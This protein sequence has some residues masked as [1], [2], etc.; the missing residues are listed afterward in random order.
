MELEKAGK[1]LQK[2]TEGQ[3]TNRKSVEEHVQL[4][5]T[6]TRTE[7]KKRVNAMKER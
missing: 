6:R 7:I 3:V 2:G 4:R 1:G 5:T